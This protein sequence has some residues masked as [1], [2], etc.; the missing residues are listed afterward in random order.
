MGI[1]G[2]CIV[3]SLTGDDPLK[4]YISAILGILAGM[5][6]TD[7]VSTVTRFTLR[8]VRLQGGFSSLPVLMGLFAISPKLWPPRGTSTQ[9]SSAARS[10]RRRCFPKKEWLKGTGKTTVVSSLIGTIIGILPGI[11]QA[12]ASL[13]AYTT[14]KQSSKHPEKF[15]TG[16]SEGVVASEAANNAVCGGALI[17]MMAIGIPGDVI[18]SILLGA[19]VLHGLQPGALLFNSNPNVVGV[20]F[21]GYILAN[22]LMYVMQLGMMRAFVQM[23]RIP[24]N[25]LYPIIILACLVGGIATNNRVFDAGV[26][27]GFGI[28]AYLMV[29][30]KYPLPPMVLGYVLSG[31]IEKN[32]R[33]GHD[34]FR[35]QLPAAVQPPHRAG[36]AGCRCCHGV[37]ADDPQPDRQKEGPPRDCGNQRE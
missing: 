3:I 33:T 19:L 36:A 17:P 29:N 22:I 8:T 12:T 37:P 4:G 7:S 6:G 32:F 11:G 1:M 23:L 14:A 10:T 34:R 28:L 2:L 27:V 31:V 25:L 24:V 15:G 30:N 13:L 9:R 21:A 26:L 20:I 35:R 18:T 5:V 16:C